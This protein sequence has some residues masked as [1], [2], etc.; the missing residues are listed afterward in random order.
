MIALLEE[1]LTGELRIHRP[2]VP[3]DE[4]GTSAYDRPPD[5]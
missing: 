3:R 1:V 4:P 5:R 2:A